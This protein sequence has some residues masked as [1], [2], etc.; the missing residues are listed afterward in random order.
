M[1]SSPNFHCLDH[2]PDNSFRLLWFFMRFF[3][4]W[5]SHGLIFVNHFIRIFAFLIFEILGAEKNSIFRLFFFVEIKK[6]IDFFCFDFLKS[7]K[8]VFLIFGIALLLCCNILVF[9]KYFFWVFIRGINFENDLGLI[10]FLKNYPA[11]GIGLDNHIK[12]RQEEFFILN[13]KAFVG[14]V[15]EYFAQCDISKLFELRYVDI[16]CLGKFFFIHEDKFSAYFRSL[17]WKVT[18]LIVVYTHNSLCW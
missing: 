1:Q 6:V 12:S 16:V 18:K 9:L 15:K 13:F 3:A 5:W 10:K 17:C 2:L 7:T 4:F 14:Q 11:E 8:I